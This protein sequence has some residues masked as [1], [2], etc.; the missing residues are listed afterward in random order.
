ML[1]SPNLSLKFKKKKKKLM[2]KILFSYLILVLDVISLISANTFSVE[3]S[4]VISI[5]IYSL[6]DLCV[7]T[8]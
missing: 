1:F 8:H 3:S 4:Q 2:Y 6:S 7:V 5:V